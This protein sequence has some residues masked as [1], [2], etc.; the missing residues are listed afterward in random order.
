[1]QIFYHELPLEE[2]FTLADKPKRDRLIRGREVSNCSG[3]AF[4]SAIRGQRIKCWNC[5]CVADR[6]IVSKGRN[7]L[8][9][10][11]VLNLYGTTKRGEVRLMTRDHIIPKSLG[12]VDLNENLRPGC[13][14]CN[15]DRGNSVNKRDLAFMNT[16]PHL[17]SQARVLKGIE[18]KAR[19]AERLAEAAARAS[20]NPSS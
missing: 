11:P 1:M 18:A 17:I 20:R 15:G 19:A 13:E 14:V 5:S 6:W 10:S 8:R 7:D 4:F 2:G 12:G 16:H 3:I 9:S